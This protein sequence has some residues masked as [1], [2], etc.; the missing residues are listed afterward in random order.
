MFEFIS[1]VIGLLL[2]MIIMLIFIWIFYYS[3]LF[4]FTYC[5]KQTPIY[6]PSNYYINPGDA[7]SNGS[8]INDILFINSQNELFYKQVSKHNNNHLSGLGIHISHPQYCQFFDNT[9]N[10]IVYKSSSFGSNI[11]NPVDGSTA[12]VVTTNANCSPISE[13]FTHGIPLI[14]WD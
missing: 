3:R 7:I 8:D 12:P 5:P 4:I 9:D 10:S 14:K 13:I 1:F 2:G 6:D 11:Y